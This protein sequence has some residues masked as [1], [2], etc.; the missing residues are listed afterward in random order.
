MKDA[1]VPLSL[2]GKLELSMNTN[3]LINVIIDGF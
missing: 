2:Q 1:L 3:S